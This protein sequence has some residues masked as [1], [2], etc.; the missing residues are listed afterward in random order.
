MAN[1][2]SGVPGGQFLS[3]ASVRCMEWASVSLLVALSYLVSGII[4]YI[5]GFGKDSRP[6]YFI[7]PKA[8]RQHRE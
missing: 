4:D 6:S 5:S 2:D 1:R 3:I 8:R 7:R